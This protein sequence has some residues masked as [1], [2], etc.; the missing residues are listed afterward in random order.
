MSTKLYD[1]FISNLELKG[2]AKRSIDSKVKSVMQL[3][4]FCNKSLSRI[5]QADLREYW[6]ACK[7]DYG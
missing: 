3:Q 6:L 7:G 2:Y 4:R 5:T 1:G